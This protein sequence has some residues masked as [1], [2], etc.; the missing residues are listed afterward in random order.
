MSAGVMLAYLKQF[1]VILWR[2]DYA[3][4]SI[5]AFPCLPGPLRRAMMVIEGDAFARGFTPPLVPPL[6]GGRPVEAFMKAPPSP[7]GR[8]RGWGAR[9][10]QVTRQGSEYG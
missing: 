1:K 5:H 7:T 4:R 2:Y 10:M 8:E 3:L 9:V 6:R